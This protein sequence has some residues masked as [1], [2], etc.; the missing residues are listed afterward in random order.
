VKAAFAK[1]PTPRLPYEW[2][3]RYVLDRQEVSL[4]LSGMGNAGQIWENAAIA[5]S[6]RPNSLTR[7]ERAIFD[8]ARGL[9]KE[10]EKVPCTG[11]GYCQ[12]CPSGVVIPEVFSMYNAGSMFDMRKDRSGWYKA[13][14]VADG[15]D[16]SVCTRCGACVP[17]CP[18]GIAIPDR[19]EEAHSYLTAE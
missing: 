4:V 8:E 11:C 14:L 19:L 18:Q 12:P 5:S 6:A 1:Y 10:R 9:F 15:H 17:K 13:S 2:A 7:P 3:L 16:A